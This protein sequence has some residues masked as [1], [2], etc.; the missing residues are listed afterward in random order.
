MSSALAPVI[1]GVIQDLPAFIERTLRHEAACQVLVA[2][3][4]DLSGYIEAAKARIAQEKAAQRLLRAEIASFLQQRGQ[5]RRAN[6]S[7]TIDE[8]SMVLNVSVA[9]TDREDSIFSPDGEFD[10]S[11]C[12]QESPLSLK[13][14][15]KGRIF[16]DE[17]QVAPKRRRLT[18]AVGEPS[19]SAA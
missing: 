5:I 6:S 1:S 18:V 3:C 13:S 19:R 4:S 10:I 7:R 12:T 15:R 16:S 8:S 14:K 11:T 9:E 2:Q 17:L